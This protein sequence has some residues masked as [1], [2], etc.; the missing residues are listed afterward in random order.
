MRERSG[1]CSPASS[2]DPVWLRQCRLVRLVGCRASAGRAPLDLAI[3]W[4]SA[5]RSPQSSLRLGVLPQNGAAGEQ[6]DP[7]TP[8]QVGVAKRAEE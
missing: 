4:S 5:R 3:P 7:A 8:R 2:S 6:W 1:N